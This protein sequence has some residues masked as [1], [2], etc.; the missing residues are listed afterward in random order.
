MI[1]NFID[2]KKCCG[3]GACKEVCPRKAIK[4]SEDSEGFLQ[5]ELIKELCIDCGICDNACPIKNPEKTVHDVIL[6]LAAINK[7]I[8]ILNNTSVNFYRKIKS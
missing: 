7:N 5:P 1:L 4:M 6:P 2:N 8:K 3:C